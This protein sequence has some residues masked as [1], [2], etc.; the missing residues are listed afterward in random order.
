MV[1]RVAVNN[2]ISRYAKL[3]SA[4]DNNSEFTEDSVLHLT[5]SEKRAAVTQLNGPLYQVSQ[6]RVMVLLRLDS[7]LSDGM[8]VYNHPRITVEHVMPQNP[9]SGSEWEKWCPS[10]D[11]HESL[12]HSLGNLALLSRTKNSAANNYDF[13]KKKIAYFN[14]KSGHTAFVLTGEVMKENEWTPAIINNRQKRLLNKLIAVWDL[15]T[16]ALNLDVDKVQQ[17]EVVA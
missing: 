12:V 9:K 2:R 4:I 13:N 14:P 7:E 8:A 11:V 17:Q 16:P 6:I 10:A 1:N 5:E 3:L 15:D